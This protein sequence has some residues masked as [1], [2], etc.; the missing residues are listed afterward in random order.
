MAASLVAMASEFTLGKEKYRKVGPRIAQILS[1]SLA[2][3]KRLATLADADVRA[4]RKKD[5]DQAMGLLLAAAEKGMT[6]SYA[7][8][9]Q[10]YYIKSDGRQ[11]IEYATKGAQAGEGC[12]QGFWI[13]GTL[14]C[15]AG[16]LCLGRSQGR[17]E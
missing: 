13:G 10:L 4:Y 5:L 15:L 14:M 8:L 11:V 12:D 17:E 2:L 9:S 7:K 6:R 3:Q 1:K 16:F